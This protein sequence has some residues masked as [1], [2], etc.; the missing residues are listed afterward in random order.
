[1]SDTFDIA[2]ELHDIN[3]NLIKLNDTIQISTSTLYKGIISA[4][5]IQSAQNA[6]ERN[7]AMKEADDFIN[8]I[9]QIGGQNG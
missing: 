4:A 2:V 3:Q 1:M 7:T 8:Q 9:S 5:K 6:F